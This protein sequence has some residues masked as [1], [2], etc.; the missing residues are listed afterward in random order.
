MVAIVTGGARG[1]GYEVA[2]KLT[3]LGMHVIIDEMM[4]SDVNNDSRAQT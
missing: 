2:R 1:L 3:S 4:E